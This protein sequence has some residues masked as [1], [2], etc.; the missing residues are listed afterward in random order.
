MSTFPYCCDTNTLY[1]GLDS[2]CTKPAVLCTLHG[3]HPNPTGIMHNIMPLTHFRSVVN[4]LKF[5]MSD[6]VTTL[7]EKYV[8]FMDDL[9][10]EIT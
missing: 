1:V 2:Q 4:E 9:I 7:V 8:N 3:T 5:Q 6:K 10:A